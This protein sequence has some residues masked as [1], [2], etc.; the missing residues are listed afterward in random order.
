[1]SALQVALGTILIL[2]SKLFDGVYS[3]LE[4]NDY[5]AEIDELNAG[6]TGMEGSTQ[7]VFHLLVTPMRTRFPFY[8]V[9]VSLVLGHKVRVQV[10]GKDLLDFLLNAKIRYDYSVNQIFLDYEIPQS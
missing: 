8:I 1:M 2:K 4:V 9:Q 10:S 7:H 6:I 5:D 3:S